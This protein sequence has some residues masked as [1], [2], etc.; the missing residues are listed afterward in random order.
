MQLPGRLAAAIEVLTDL[1]TRKRPASEA[2]R[3]WGTSHR[4]A[5]SGDR[6]AIGNLVYD[7]L[8]RRA[9]HAH[10]MGD[11]TPRALVLSVAVRDWGETPDGL[12]AAFATDRFAPD[13]PTEAEME[14]LAAP[15][16]LVGAPDH[17]KADIPDWLAPAFAE[18]FGDSWIAEGQGMTHRPPVD[19]RVNRLK[20][21]VAR[22]EKSLKRFAPISAPIVPDGLRLPAGPRDART[23]NVLVDEAYLKGWFEVQ[24]AGS[25]A[26][27]ALASAASGEQ[28]LDFCA[29]AGGKTLALAAAM[30][31][32]GQIFAHDADRFRLAPIYDR[33]K[34]A[35]VRNV[36]VRPPEENVLFDLTGRM[37]LVLVDAPC[38]GTGTWR[39]RPDA[40]WR[41]SP[42]QLAARVAEQAAIL[43]SA[44][45]HVR[46]GGRL[47]YITCSLLPAENTGTIAAFRARYPDFVPVD[48]KA[49]FAE[50]FA[51]AE[52]VAGVGAE[53][54]WLSPASAGTDGF[55]LSVLRRG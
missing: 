45:R 26:V 8:R 37:D 2:L 34:R 13:P 30:G 14:R 46:P 7:A 44:A 9:S 55:F 38:T 17:V 25:Q 4:F 48:H 22:V 21:D 49:L 27:A 42:E 16:P 43:D 19:L 6:A 10:A 15:D 51:S 47:A 28:V 33:L 1:E 11:E 53:A 31:N 40:K 54:I 36:Q 18:A 52:P 39:R 41:L 23:P 20:S 5:G 50:S 12:A 29:G 3:D 35:G 32:R 24:D